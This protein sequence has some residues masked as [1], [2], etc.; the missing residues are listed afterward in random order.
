MKEDTIVRAY[1]IAK[2]EY[3]EQGV[4]TDAALA[5]LTAASDA[6]GVFNLASGHP[7]KLR[8]AVE[9]IFALVASERQPEYGMLSTGAPPCHLVARVGKLEA[10]L[11]WA[12]SVSLADGLA[13]TVRRHL[14]EQ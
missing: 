5:R 8:E 4:D 13:R 10:E 14:E 3:A 9:K 12:P 11:D 7:I 1:E 2:E 6:T